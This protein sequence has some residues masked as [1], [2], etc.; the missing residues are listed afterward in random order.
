MRHSNT[1]RKWAAASGLAGAALLITY[2]AAPA[3]LAWPYAGDT[4]SHL[5]AYALGH[6][7][8]FYAGAWLQGTG[9]MLS[10]VFFLALAG[11]TGALSRLPG[12]LVAVGAGALL[13]V[14]LIESALLVAV[15]MAAA[16]GDLATVSTTFA[17]SNGVFVRVFPLAPSSLTYVALG[18]V[19]ARSQV[20]PR[21][22]G[23]AAIGLGATFEVGGIAAVFTSWAVPALAV[24]GAAQALWIIAAAARLWWAAD[25]EPGELR[26]ASPAPTV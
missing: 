23:Y 15:P 21:S 25:G 20:L 10:V 8:L 4:P 6:Q 18:I 22:L 2:F 17:L 19:I 11:M 12:A 13:A 5:S 16:S 1:N 9:T 24:L 7:T 3:I 14:V 26:E